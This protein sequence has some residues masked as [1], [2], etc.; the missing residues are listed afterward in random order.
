[1]NRR[2]AKAALGLRVLRLPLRGDDVA[3][4]DGV[5][6][7]RVDETLL[8]PLQRLLIHAGDRRGH[9]EQGG[10]ERAGRRAGGSPARRRRRG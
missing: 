6:V 9:A 8:D 7:D 10:A 4:G 5:G 3:V 1:M 2:G